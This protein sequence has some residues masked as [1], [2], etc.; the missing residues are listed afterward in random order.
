MITKNSAFSFENG[1]KMMNMDSIVLGILAL[2]PAV[3]LCVY[4]FVKDRNEKEPLWLLFLLIGLGAVAVFPAMILEEGASA[5]TNGIFEP[6]GYD[7]MGYYI[8]PDSVY[9]AYNIVDNFVG[10]ALIE[11]GLKWLIMF[12]VTRKSKQFNSLFDGIVF[13]VFVSLG[14]AALENIMYVF[15]YGFDTAIIRMFVSVP[16]HAF[17]GVIMGMFYSIWHIETGAKKIETELISSGKIIV[18]PKN[19]SRFKTGSW[20]AKSLIIPVLCHGFFDFCCSVDNELFQYLRYPF[21]IILYVYCFNKVRKMSKID[22]NDNIGS[23]VRFFAVYPEIEEELK[24]QQGINN[25]VEQKQN[26]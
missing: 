22:I 24:K 25:N 2:L 1:G 26:I 10:V 21:I 14:F 8:Y 9:Y 18:Y 19:T 20:L 23:L 16:A 17:F 5:V 7:F 15:S 6:F 12:F 13:A 4:I 11:E 3:V